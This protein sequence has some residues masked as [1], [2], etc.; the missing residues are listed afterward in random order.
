MENKRNG[1]KE[2]RSGAQRREKALWRPHRYEQQV[3]NPTKIAKEEKKIN[4]VGSRVK[5]A[6]ASRA[7]AQQDEQGW[8]GL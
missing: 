2:L 8:L 7:M 3:P 5:E 1:K 6:G 4:A